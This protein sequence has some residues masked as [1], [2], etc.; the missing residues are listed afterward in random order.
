MKN[1]IVKRVK[2]VDDH[3]HDGAETVGQRAVF[4]QERMCATDNRNG[5][6]SKPEPVCNIVVTNKGNIPPTN[7]II[8]TA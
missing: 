4:H 7:G 2:K 3:D 5:I 1:E 6:I 8:G